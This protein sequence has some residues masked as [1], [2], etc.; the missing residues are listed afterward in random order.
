ML[1]G[2]VQVNGSSLL[3]EAQVALF[4]E[5]GTQVRLEANSDA[6]LLLLSGEPIEE[7]IVGYGPFVMNKEEEIQ[8]AI[9]DFQAGAFGQ[10]HG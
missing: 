8:Q 2:A 1:S 9:K 7:P 10:M 6:K 4:S 3:R 5:E